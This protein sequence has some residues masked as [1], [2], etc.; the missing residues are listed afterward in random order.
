[1]TSGKPAFL[2]HGAPGGRNGP[3]PRGTVL[4]RL[5]IRLICYDRPGYQG[6]DPKPG[7]TVASAA[8][9]VRIIADYLGTPLLCVGGPEGAP[10]TLASA[11]LLPDR[12][13]TATVLC[14]QAP[15]DAED[16]D[17]GAGMTE[18]RAL[19]YTYAWMDAASRLR[20]FL[21]RQAERASQVSEGLPSEPLREGADHGEED[22]DGVG[23][24]R[25]D[26]GIHFDELL[27]NCMD[28][29]IDDL[30]ALSR[31][32]EIRTRQDNGTGKVFERARRCLLAGQSYVLAGD[33][34]KRIRSGARARE[35]PLQHDPPQIPH[36]GGGKGKRGTAGNRPVSELSAVLTLHYAL[37]RV[38]KVS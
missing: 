29:W 13:I 36:I 17:W 28:R 26:A 10:H 18:S 22:L 5:D 19:A 23:F 33:A 16:L 37:G 35:S 20:A 3:R 8:E 25:V 38:S 21:D 24:R 14:G 27:N 1:M 12:V 7:R 15:R 31:P 30:I 9:D 6:S 32:W 34:D 4:Y 2:L 11:A